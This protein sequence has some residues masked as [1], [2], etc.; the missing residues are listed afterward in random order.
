M[1]SFADNTLIPLAAAFAEHHHDGQL[2]RGS[3]EPYFN[4]VKRVAEAVAKMD[5]SV[6]AIAAAYLH[7]VVEDTDVTFDDLRAAGFPERTV[8]L[9]WWLTKHN[10]EETYESYI[11]RLLHSGN[12]EALLI[13][14]ADL[15]DNSN[16]DYRYLWYKWQDA[17]R[18]YTEAKI[19]IVAKLS[20]CVDEER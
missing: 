10:P 11:Y 17:Q 18:R 20:T 6:E 14:L 3:S 5:G 15:N 13:K 1:F 8:D 16:I 9:V 7:D 12:R 4:H 2:R 19:K